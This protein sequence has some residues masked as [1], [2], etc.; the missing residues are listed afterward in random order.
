[1]IPLPFVKFFRLT[2]SAGKSRRY[3]AKR[4]LET[5][6]GESSRP[7]PSET[8]FEGTDLGYRMPLDK[9]RPLQNERFFRTRS[10]LKQITPKLHSV[11]SGPGAI[12]V[13][14]PRAWVA[15]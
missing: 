2:S 1:M 13:T 3:D 8:F 4:P 12:L 5:G 7:N 6:R 10:L 9:I 11:F 15:R 14:S